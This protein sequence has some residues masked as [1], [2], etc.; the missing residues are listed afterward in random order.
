MKEFKDEDFV[1]RDVRAAGAYGVVYQC[2]MVATEGVYAMKEMKFSAKPS[3]REKIFKSFHKEV[4]VL[5][6]LSPHPHIVLLLGY[7][8]AP[9]K[10]SLIMKLYDASLS[11]VLA[12]RLRQFKMGA[13]WFP[14]ADVKKF[15]V[16]ILEGLSFL[17]SNLVA[18]RDLKPDNVLVLYQPG[19]V[20]ASLHLSDFGT[21][22]TISKI[23]LAPTVGIGTLD[24]MAPEMFK[25][26][27]YDPF[28]S[29]VW[30]FGVLLFCLLCPG[31]LKRKLPGTPP[32]FPEQQQQLQSQNQQEQE[33]QQLVQSFKPFFDM[34]T[35]QEPTSRPTAS[36]ILAEFKKI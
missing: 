19:Q 32:Q 9:E 36:M 5:E 13:A 23:T 34:C 7:I 20:V 25:D 6:K 28:A 18:H 2:S 17:H 12:T 15:C 29:D 11:T 24:F 33:L 1:K 8:V 22:K 30:S 16:E 31:P 21:A 26:E 14:A 3:E 4:E 10:L 27:K 35:Q